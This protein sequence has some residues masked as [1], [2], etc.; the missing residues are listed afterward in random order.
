MPA[1]TDDERISLMSLVV[2]AHRHLTDNL[3]RELEQAVGIPPVFFDVLIHVA[4]AP[5]GRLT[6]SRL[7]ADVALTASGVTRLVDRMVEADLVVRENSPSDRRSI[8][9]VLTRAGQAVLKRA[10]AGYV[11]SIDRHLIAPLDDDDRAALT[12]TLIKVLGPDR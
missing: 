7:S 6:M 1:Q 9:V 11:E 4:A 3:G 2:R 10:I 8:H 12:V 5:R